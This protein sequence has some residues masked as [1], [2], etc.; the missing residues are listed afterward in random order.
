[1]SSFS[2][3][4]LVIWIATA[5]LLLFPSPWNWFALTALLLLLLLLF[6]QMKLLVTA[7]LLASALIYSFHT[8]A[9]QHNALTP[10]LD[11]KVAVK[12]IG[13]FAT[14]PTTLPAKKLAGFTLPVRYSA[15]INASELIVQGKITYLRLPIRVISSAALFLQFGEVGEVVGYLAKTKENKVAALLTSRTGAIK[16][17]AADFITR[18]S[19]SL[20]NDFH[21]ASE[22]IK[23]ASGSLIPGFILGDTS[24]ESDQ[25]KSQMQ[26]VG[27]THLTAVSGE[28][29]SI[30]AVALGWLLVKLIKNYRFRLFIVAL[31]SLW[32]IYLARPQGSVMRAGVMVGLYLWGKW[33]GLAI[34]PISALTGSLAIL[35]LFD[36]FFAVDPGFVLSFLAT[37]GIFLFYPKFYESIKAKFGENRISKIIALSLSASLPTIPIVVWLSGQLSLTS[38]LANG[39]VELAVAP[40]TILGLIAALLAPFAPGATHLILVLVN[41][42]C[43]WIVLVA[44]LLSKIPVIPFAKGAPGALCSLLL[45]GICALFFRLWRSIW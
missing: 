36:P 18:I 9:L 13:R 14:D 45:L 40:I 31:A 30:L 3:L 5:S 2:K 32:F 15:L 8:Y 7:L 17:G 34:E 42:F 44:E 24:L 1:M 10:L 21:L 4:S 43:Q 39:L 29:F 27:L 25:F 12:L 37:I 22:Q 38:I 16:V 41:P 23:G 19:N 33:F 11:K 20:R 28:N 35:I 26:A 6:S